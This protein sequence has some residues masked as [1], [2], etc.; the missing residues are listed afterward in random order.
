MLP[1]QSSTHNPDFS[2]PLWS[3]IVRDPQKLCSITRI[4]VLVVLW[5]H[6]A[7]AKRTRSFC[8]TDLLLCMW[9]IISFEISN[10]SSTKVD[11]PDSSKPLRFC[12]V[13]YPRELCST[14]RIGVL[15]TL[16]DHT[17]CAYFGCEYEFLELN[18][19]TYFGRDFPDSGS[20]YTSKDSGGEIGVPYEAYFPMPTSAA[21]KPWYSFA[22]GPVHFTVMS[23]EHNWTSGS[24]QVSINLLPDKQDWASFISAF[25]MDFEGLSQGYSFA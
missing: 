11:T 25:I 14:T 19:F 12:I 2:K 21:D 17:Y 16:W 20:I 5:D 8:F 23:T 15:V 13:T 10:Q 22:S 18:G 4:D 9:L 1:N 24:E 7:F 3:S 6:I